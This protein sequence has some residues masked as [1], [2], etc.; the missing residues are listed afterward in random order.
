[1]PKISK[2]ER[3]MAKQYSDILKNRVEM[4]GEGLLDDV[5]DFVKDAGK[6]IYKA[7]KWVIRKAR[8]IHEGIFDILAVFGLT[9][10]EGLAAL[11]EMLK[12]T[13]FAKYKKY[14]DGAVL[15]VKAADEEL[16]ARRK[17][18]AEQGGSGAELKLK[19]SS[20]FSG[21][22]PKRVK[23]QSGEGLISDARE[24]KKCKDK[25]DAFKRNH[26]RTSRMIGLG[27]TS[28]TIPTSSASEIYTPNDSKAEGDERG[29]HSGWAPILSAPNAGGKAK[30]MF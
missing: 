19:D 22:K 16:A 24:L 17:R 4:N 12:D 25:A 10:A 18:E 5:F 1:M 21:S 2:Q 26:P 3:R 8:E 6:K 9:P 14:L 11:S 30:A 27:E 20:K 7:G 13:K 15:V 23:V 29:A 28:K